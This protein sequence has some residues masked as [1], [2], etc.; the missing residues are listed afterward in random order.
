MARLQKEIPLKLSTKQGLRPT[1][2]VIG[3]AR[4]DHDTLR[5]AEEVGYALIERGFRVLTGGLGGVMEAALKGARRAPGYRE[6]DTIAVLPTYAHTDANAFADVIIC[7]GL[8]HG[9]NT[10]VAASAH[11]IIVVGGRAGTLNEITMAWNLGRPIIAVDVPGWGQRLA[12]ESLDDRLDHKIEGP[13]TPQLAAARAAEL[14]DV[15]NTMRHE[16]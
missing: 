10:I 15:S 7:T 4:A 12:G 8:N 2:A 11:V 13:F 5:A 16:F 14:I 1:A 9:R 6:G 3:S